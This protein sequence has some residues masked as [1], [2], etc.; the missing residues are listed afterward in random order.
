MSPTASAQGSRRDAPEI[1]RDLVRDT[2]ESLAAVVRR[3]YMDAETAGRV[4]ASLRKRLASDRYAGAR[5]REDLAAMLTRDLFELTR[6]KHLSVAVLPDRTSGPAPGP[7]P[8]ESREATARRSNFGI[9]RVE[10]L[11]G[12]IGY[13]NITWFYRPDE[14]RQAISAAMQVLRNA[15]ALILDLR[16]NGGGSPETV[17]LVASYLFDS[18]GL[19][20]FEIAPRSGDGGRTYRTEAAS[21]PETDGRRPVYA[22]TS[23]RTFSGGE[24]LA[25]IL[26]ERQRAEVIGETT[27]GAANPGRPYPLNARFEATVPNGKVQSAVRRGNW[28]GRG[29]TPDV[30]TPASEALRLTQRRALRRLVDG[31]A[32]GV[33]RN[34]LEREIKLLEQR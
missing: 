21:L 6:D 20:L 18:P 10:I 5:S 22:L 9:Q 27:A 15:D 28:E 29:V 24:G 12:N 3:E 17:A 25:F 13:L 32:T 4:D 7:L 26:Q 1:D 11:P 34:S 30:K 14:A 33:W 23:E 19:P 16:G 8:A 2:V 31:T